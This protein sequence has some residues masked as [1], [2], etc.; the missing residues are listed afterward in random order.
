MHDVTSFWQIKLK[1]SMVAN[2][3]YWLSCLLFLLPSSIVAEN[4]DSIWVKGLGYESFLIRM[5]GNCLLGM[6]G[7]SWSFGSTANCTLFFA[8]RKH[9]WYV[10]S[11]FPCD[12]LSFYLQLHVQLQFSFDTSFLLFKSCENHIQCIWQDKIFLSFRQ[13]YCP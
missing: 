11:K 1:L 3:D 10:H 8:S 12:I 6:C 7:K 4:I 13:K 5:I 2:T 9:F